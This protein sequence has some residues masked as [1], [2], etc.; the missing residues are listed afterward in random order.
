MDHRG[1]DHFGKESIALMHRNLGKWEMNDYIEVVKWLRT[2]PFIDSTK[3]CI[4]GSSYGGYV[5]CLALTYGADYFTHG[6][7]SSSVTDWKLYD[8]HYTEMYMDTPSENPEGYKNGS[9]MT[10]ASKYKGMLMIIHGT[11]DDNVHMQ[12]IVQLVGAL[13][14]QNRHFELMI[15]PGGRHGWGGRKALH[16]RNEAYR[17]YYQYLLGKKFPENLFK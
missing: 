15:Y 14:D 4:T 16:S 7:A 9:V 10:Y 6:V 11:M 17:F 2:Q 8:S 3:V 1:S 5:T 12:N 13:E